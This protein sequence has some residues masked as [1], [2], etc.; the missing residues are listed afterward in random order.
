MLVEVSKRCTACGQHL[1]LDAFFLNA[2]GR[3]GRHSVCRSCSYKYDQN[4][5][6]AILRLGDDRIPASRKCCLCKAT[7]PAASFGKSA[8]SRNGLRTYCKECDKIVRRAGKYCLTPA[9]VAEMLC[10]RRCEAC[11]GS[12]AN[13]SEKHFDH[14]HADGAV[15]GVLCGRCN[16]TLGQCQEN[17]AILIALCDYLERTKDVDYRNQPYSVTKKPVLDTDLTGEP[18]LPPEEQGQCQT[19]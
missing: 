3:Y 8:G 17:P 7:L 16:T 11:G 4:K 14:R 10:R 6:A 2:K 9:K 5:R 13:D 15:R 1:R 18:R 19:K 12:F